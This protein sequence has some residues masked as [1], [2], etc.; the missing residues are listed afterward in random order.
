M[1]KHKDAAKSLWTDRVSSLGL[2][3]VALATI[4]A[5]GIGLLPVSMPDPLV[6]GP[7]VFKT[8]NLHVRIQHIT[9]DLP[10]DNVLPHVVSEFFLRHISFKDE[11]PILPGQEVSNRPV[12]M[13]LAVLPFRDMLAPPERQH[14][15]LGRFTYVGS[16]WPDV[17]PLADDADFLQFL[18]VAVVL[19]ALLMLGAALMMDHFS[20]APRLRGLTIG[21]LLLSPYFISQIL[22]TW[23][24][25]LAG[26]FLLLALHSLLTKKDPRET[27]VWTACAYWSHPYAAV[28]AISFAIYFYTSQKSTLI[29]E[30][31]RAAGL[32]SFTWSAIILPWFLWTRVYL[33]IPSDLVTQNALVHSHTKDFLW[34]R[35]YNVYQLISPVMLAQYPLGRENFFN[36]CLVCVPGLTGLLLFFPAYARLASDYRADKLVPLFYIILP[37]TLVTLVFSNPAV[38]ALHGFQA[39]GPVLVMMAVRWMQDK[40]WEMASIQRVLMLQIALNIVVWWQKLASLHIKWTA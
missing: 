25:A 1:R 36:A 22:F 29:K 3:S 39:I 26:F 11:R 8:H 30:K 5:L 32:F 2:S 31:V 38:P 6:D 13:S 4:I 10:A 35:I 16:S 20:I 12:L 27:A 24:K 23:P 15:R 9:G 7:Y 28:F 34:A 18:C 40:D 19:N 17:E 21:A 33:R 14:G 37:A